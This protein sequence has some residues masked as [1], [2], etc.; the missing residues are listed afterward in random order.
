MTTSI[1]PTAR[2][3]AVLTTAIAAGVGAALLVASGYRADL[4]PGNPVSF[5]YG[6]F[7]WLLFLAGSAAFVAAIVWRWRIGDISLLKWMAWAIAGLLATI[8]GASLILNET[9]GAQL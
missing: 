2:N 9:L 1:G 7:A 4:D 6:D 5:P 8:I 3:I